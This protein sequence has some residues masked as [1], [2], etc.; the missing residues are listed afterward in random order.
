M[1]A[2]LGLFLALALLSGLLAAV[3]ILN[4]KTR[5][6][7]WV[8]TQ[9]D[10]Y[11]PYFD[12]TGPEYILENLPPPSPRLKALVKKRFPAPKKATELGL[13][14]QR[15]LGYLNGVYGYLSLN[16]NP[17]A[18]HVSDPESAARASAMHQA[19]EEIHSG[20]LLQELPELSLARDFAP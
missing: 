4:N 14:S 19:L 20:T 11:Y 12:P 9:L 17:K 8:Q 6:A 2:G 5:L 3:V 7:P 1:K 13:E 15:R 16:K 18:P 10:S